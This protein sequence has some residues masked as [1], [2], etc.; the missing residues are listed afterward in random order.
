MTRCHFCKADAISQFQLTS[1]D[2]YSWEWFLCMDCALMC[3]S[4]GYD[5]K[6]KKKEKGEGN[7]ERKEKESEK[8]I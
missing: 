5:L 3:Q 4:Q 2:G 6:V 8:A 1:S 7:E